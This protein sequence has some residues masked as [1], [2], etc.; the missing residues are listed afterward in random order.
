MHA[1]LFIPGKRQGQYVDAAD[2]TGLT[3]SRLL[4]VVD[5]LSSTRFLVDTGA[6]VS[7]IPPY[8][9]DKKSPSALTLQAANKT[10]ISTYGTR[11][12]TL[13]LGLHCTFR[14]VFVVADVTNAI[15]GADFLQHCGL[16]VDMKQRCLTDTTTSL[17]VN[18]VVA[19]AMSPS[20]SLL[21]QNPTNQFEAIIAEFPAVTQPCVASQSVKHSVTHHM[22]TT[23]S[24]VSGRTR[25]LSPE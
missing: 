18:G 25:R 10:T 15:L 21:P 20:P 8:P 14:L 6:Q 5:S 9:Q 2:V 19:A 11:S 24:P 4:F 16:V 13:N 7:V 22:T 3:P 1:T 17:K 12:R 23:G